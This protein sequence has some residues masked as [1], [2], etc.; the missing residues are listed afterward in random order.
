MNRKTTFFEKVLLLVGITS[1]ILGFYLIN[2]IYQT[3]GELLSYDMLVVVF[4]WIILLFQIV[5]TATSENQKEE[6]GVITKG[7]QEETKLMKELLKEQVYE[8]K[9][10]RNDLRELRK[11][12]KDINPKSSKKKSK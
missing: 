2:N 4:L 9:L 1:A 11:I 7:L 6:L 8:V 3:K 12:E 5:Q 10:L